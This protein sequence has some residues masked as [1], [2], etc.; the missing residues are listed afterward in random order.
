MEPEAGETG[1]AGFP[2]GPPSIDL[3]QLPSVP[4]ADRTF[5]PSSFTLKLLHSLGTH[6]INPAGTGIKLEW[7][8]CGSLRK[9]EFLIHKPRASSAL[10]HFP[11]GGRSSLLYSYDPTQLGNLPQG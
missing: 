8:H 2:Q 11:H 3:S 7:G 9:L 5:P 1:A 4:D 6:Q 10:G